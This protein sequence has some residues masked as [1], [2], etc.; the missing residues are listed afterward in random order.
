MVVWVTLP[1]PRLA[2][3]NTPRSAHPD[4]E[5]AALVA[6]RGAEAV[7]VEN[8]SVRYRTDAGPVTA[9]DGITFAL[10]PGETMAVVGE[11]GSGKTTFATA[12]A[13]LIPASVAEV[14]CDRAAI[15]GVEID[16]STSGNLVPVRREGV[17]MVFQ[18]A[19][20]SLDP[21]ATIGHQFRTVLGGRGPDGERLSRAEIRKRAI[22]WTTKVGI[23]DPE[24]VLRL[25]PY[26]LS[27]GMRQR[28]M[29]ALGL[30]SRPRVL[31][32]DEPTSALDAS[33]SR[34]IMDLVMELTAE[35]GT[36]LIV[37][38]HDIDLARA[39]TDRTLVLYRGVMQDNVATGDLGSE[40]LSPY[41]RAL[42]RCVPRME[43]RNRARLA[44]LDSLLGDSVADG[45]DSLPGAPGVDH[46]VGASTAAG[47][48]A[49]DASTDTTERGGAR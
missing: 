2:N 48:S 21:V 18:D 14:T 30:C 3:V 22:E 19:M 5:H 41:T 9:V 10:S 4:T 24:R 8:F 28:V 26:E 13:G 44:T 1:I 47:S 7:A 49:A 6:A 37:I 12:L 34:T 20:T 33:V 27:G 25:R 15:G 11:S 38:T 32:A 36:A 31:I 46:L 42:I 43:D 16:V 35:L 40:K 39:Y 45:A 17:S 29:V 23:H